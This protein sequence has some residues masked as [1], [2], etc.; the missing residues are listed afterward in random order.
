MNPRGRK[1]EG[2]RAEGLAERNGSWLLHS[3]GTRDEITNSERG[4]RSLG[5]GKT[6]GGR[7]GGIELRGTRGWME[8]GRNF[9]LLRPCLEGM[10]GRNKVRTGR[11][12][13]QRKLLE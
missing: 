13:L 1:E 7:R 9:R 11:K 6:K 3:C 8:E 4:A 12:E 10:L 5:A 2:N